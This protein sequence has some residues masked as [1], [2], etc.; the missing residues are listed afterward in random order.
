MTARIDAQEADELQARLEHLKAS[1]DGLEYSQSGD[2]GQDARSEADDMPDVCRRTLLRSLAVGGTGAAFGVALAALAATPAAAFGWTD[3]TPNF[4]AANGNPN[5]GGGIPAPGD[6]GRYYMTG[7]FVAVKT[8]IQFGGSGAQPG[9][10]QYRMSLPVAAAIGNF[11]LLVPTG[12]ALLHRHSTDIARIASVILFD[13]TRVV[14]RLDNTTAPGVTH[15][16]PWP[17]SNN[18]GFNTFIFYEAA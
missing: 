8:W 17:W 12:I 2:L 18:D 16:F 11:S 15:N 14:F 3:Y 4:T 5:L 10:G 1:I 13:A 6:H 9:S 7:G